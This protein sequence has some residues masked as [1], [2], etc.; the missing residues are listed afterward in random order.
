LKQ[1]VCYAWACNALWKRG[2][3]YFTGFFRASL[4]LHYML[5]GALKKDLSKLTPP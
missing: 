1:N 5:P 3:S 2:I 4:L